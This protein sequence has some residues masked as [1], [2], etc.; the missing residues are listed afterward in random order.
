MAVALLVACTAMLEQFAISGDDRE[1]LPDR[2][3]EMQTNKIRA[4]ICDLDK[5]PIS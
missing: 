5:T 1:R 2:A 4:I 3:D